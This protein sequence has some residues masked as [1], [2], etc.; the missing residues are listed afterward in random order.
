MM[1]LPDVLYIAMYCIVTKQW[2]FFF[3]D[4]LL[5]KTPTNGMLAVDRQD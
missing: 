5:D 3:D 1:C 2:D 4:G